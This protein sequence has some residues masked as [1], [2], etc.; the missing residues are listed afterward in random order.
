MVPLQVHHREEDLRKTNHAAKTKAA[1]I[2]GNDHC[3]R[4]KRYSEP[5]I[6]EPATAPTTT[7]TAT[8]TAPPAAATAPTATLPF[9]A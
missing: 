9:Q 2:Y 4:V 6:Y 3:C 8:A 1:R 7:T 5:I